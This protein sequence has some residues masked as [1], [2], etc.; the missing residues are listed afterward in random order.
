VLNLIKD[1]FLAFFLVFMSKNPGIQVGSSLLIMGGY[2][3]TE[4]IKK[5]MKSKKENARNQISLGVY[6]VSIMFFFG[7][8]VTDGKITKKQNELYIGYPLIA[9]VSVLIISNYVI[10]MMDTC[11][12]I[13]K[14]CKVK[15]GQ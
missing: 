10:S 4:L 6:T 12:G 11:K 7:L 3:L 5:P 1:P 9:C 14:R 15:K 2:F 13:K 8:V